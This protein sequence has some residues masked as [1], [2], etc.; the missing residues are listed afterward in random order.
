LLSGPAENPCLGPV[1]CLFSATNPR[2]TQKP[3]K[4]PLR[5]CTCNGHRAVRRRPS[6]LGLRVR[7]WVAAQPPLPPT[8]EEGG[9]PSAR[10][11][12][13]AGWPLQTHPYP[14]GPR[15]H[16]GARPWKDPVPVSG[17][18]PRCSMCFRRPAG[19]LWGGG[20]SVRGSATAVLRPRQRTP[21][22]RAELSAY[23][24]HQPARPRSAGA[25]LAETNRPGR[26]APPY[27]SR[28]PRQPPL[29]RPTFSPHGVKRAPRAPR[30]FRAA[31]VPDAA[32][33]PNRRT[34]RTPAS[35]AAASIVPTVT[36]ARA[37]TPSAVPPP[38]RPGGALPGPG[39][40]GPPRPRRVCVSLAPRGRGPSGFAGTCAAPARA[41]PPPVG[42]SRAD[43]LLAGGFRLARSGQSGQ[44]A[45]LTVCQTR[46]V[47]AAG[48]P[49]LSFQVPP[50][51]PPGATLGV[52][53]TLAWPPEGRNRTR[54]GA[55]AKHRPVRSPYRR[56]TS[57][58]Q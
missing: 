23:F 36:R 11:S 17:E 19:S 24:G 42:D 15:A 31:A 44:V 1:H 9:L 28:L 37:R 54:A 6:G 46:S 27:G 5:R 8:A 12:L 50:T 18:T 43:A 49:T 14:S 58:P 34:R 21:P 16:H 30:R 48:P 32:T 41:P 26:L 13:A 51:D 45:H 7:F 2:N 38:R 33:A 57:T 52:A 10:W 4:A 40:V 20:A 35:P 22:A 55:R 56:A 29:V 47:S 39:A 25:P 3:T 53:R